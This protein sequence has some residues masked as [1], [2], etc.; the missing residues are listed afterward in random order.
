MDARSDIEPSPTTAVEPAGMIM[1]PTWRFI[2]VS[3]LNK[4]RWE[5]FKANRRG[6]WSLW[7]FLA[8]FVLSLFAEFIANDKPMFVW[9][10]GRP[11]F[12]AVI[13]YPD[14]AFDKQHDPNLFGTAADFRDDYLMG[15]IEKEHGTV[16]WPPIHFSYNTQ[17]SHPPSPFPS[18]PTWMLT[19]KDCE[20]AAAHKFA[21]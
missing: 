19:E 20:F 14:T 13:T 4:R 18:K 12:P 10:N 5:N 2:N 11:F 15:L 7:L 6:Y 8:L 1:P 17:V 16:I 9:V 3:P 21:K